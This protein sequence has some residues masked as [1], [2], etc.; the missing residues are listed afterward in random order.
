MSI[1]CLLLAQVF[2]RQVNEDNTV[3]FSRLS[4][5]QDF[6]FMVKKYSPEQVTSAQHD[7]HR[8]TESTAITESS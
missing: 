6:P 4:C 3:L 7:T 2:K 1:I 8:I 5:C